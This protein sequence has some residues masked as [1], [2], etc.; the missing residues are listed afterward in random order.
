[1]RCACLTMSDLSPATKRWLR[2][3]AL[4]LLLGGLA[5]VGV[6]SGATQGLTVDSVRDA[7]SGAGLLGVGLFLGAFALGT[8]VQIPGMLFVI[9]AALAWGQAL[10]AIVA[11][12][13]AVLSVT[14]SFILVRRVGGQMLTEIERPF[15][16]RVLVHL[17][18]RPVRT[19]FL[20]RTVLWVA[21]PLNY[22][23]A[24]SGVSRRAYVVGSALGLVIPVTAAA[25]LVDSLV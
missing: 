14:I 19:I 21:P 2:V 7:I 15:V 24:L 17:D 22:A 10:G 11:L 8:L 4:V 16:K 5:L 13:G 12:V 1:M 9:A 18:T 6:L 3:G 20:L 25:L 23:L